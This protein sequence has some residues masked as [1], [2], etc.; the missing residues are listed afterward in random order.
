MQKEIVSQ[1]PEAAA[2]QWTTSHLRTVPEENVFERHPVEV[3]IH[4][5]SLLF[6]SP[7]LSTLVTVP[8]SEV[9][10]HAVNADDIYLQLES[11]HLSILVPGFEGDMIEVFL[12]SEG[13]RRKSVVLQEHVYIDEQCQTSFKLYR[14]VPPCIP[15]QR[16]HRSTSRP[17]INLSG[18]RLKV[19]QTGNLTTQ[20]QMARHLGNGDAWNRKKER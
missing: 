11:P 7:A 4:P 5:D 14:R 16:S 13:H 17:R 18:S 9:I 15:M 1:G 12:S 10:L 3:T 2:V 20:K 19:S 6:Y 8:Y